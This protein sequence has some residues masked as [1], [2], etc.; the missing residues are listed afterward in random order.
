[1]NLLH[2]I[3]LN[4]F[5]ETLDGLVNV[6]SFTSFIILLALS[7]L[8]TGVKVFTHVIRVKFI[9]NNEEPWFSMYDLIRLVTL[10]VAISFFPILKS[11]I[12]A[13]T[14]IVISMFNVPQETRSKLYS[15]Y[16]KN[17]AKRAVSNATDKITKK[18]NNSN[19]ATEKMADYAY[20]QAGNYSDI[21]GLD[22]SKVK[23]II[24][25]ME[26]NKLIQNQGEYDSK[27]ETIE[28]EGSQMEELGLNDYKIAQEELED[29]GF[30]VSGLIDGLKEATVMGFTWTL[31]KLRGGINYL[32]GL[33][34]CYSLAVLYA[35]GPLAFAISVFFKSAWLSWLKAI[36]STSLTLGVLGI[37]DLLAGVDMS[38]LA[39]GDSEDFF[40]AFLHPILIIALY[41]SAR[42]FTAIIFNSSGV[43]IGGGVSQ[44][45]GL[46]LMGGLGLL[47]GVS[48]GAKGVASTGKLFKGKEKQ[49]ED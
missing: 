18:L 34:I 46:L 40:A 23:N 47:K 32:V 38:S 43:G 7:V 15:N 26:E 31:D 8:F 20:T 19:K 45:G 41:L 30:S 36:L 1:M 17:I 5:K 35:L 44:M 6:S 29:E 39:S 2:N 33:F 11:T 4:D 25:Q 28:E 10:G 3:N 48:I 24:S 42:K 21:Y 9:K 14:G 16:E 22:E 12:K 27:L 49:K 13:S 37:I